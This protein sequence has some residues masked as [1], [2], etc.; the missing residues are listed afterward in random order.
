M[1]PKN[2]L[3]N[4]MWHICTAWL[5]L[6][7]PN[8]RRL[9]LEHA[10]SCQTETVGREERKEKKKGRNVSSWVHGSRWMLLIH[11]C[12]LPSYQRLSQPRN[13]RRPFVGNRFCS[14]FESSET[15]WAWVTM[16][17]ATLQVH[18]QVILSFAFKQVA[19]PS[20]I[21]CV[22][23]SR[24]AINGLD[25]FLVRDRVWQRRR[26]PQPLWWGWAGAGMG[27]LSP[28]KKENL[29][30]QAVDHMITLWIKK[31]Q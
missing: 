19:I 3:E 29:S 9:M 2:N 23:P 14:P 16:L 18:L 27:H 30:H 31:S 13:Q 12:T 26:Q 11:L 28:K 21:F 7:S 1:A 4:D 10:P 20:L 25:L 8:D 22:L 5:V 24:L 6:I 15:A 17:A